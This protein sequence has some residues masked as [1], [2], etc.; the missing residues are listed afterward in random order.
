[1]LAT[2]GERLDVYVTMKRSFS[3]AP[4]DQILLMKTFTV[5]LLALSLPMHGLMAASVT[6]DKM[7]VYVSIIPQ[8][9]LV[10][11]IGGDRVATEVMVKPGYSPETYEPAPG[12]MRGIAR[13][14]IYFRVCMPFEEV[15]LPAV[16]TGNPIRIVDCNP[17]VH[18]RMP[19]GTLAH[20]KTRP[21]P[22]IWTDPVNARYLAR[23][24]HE[25]L[26]AE[27]PRHATYYMDNFK[28]LDEEL[29]DLHEY[30]TGQISLR[31]SP[32]LLV[33]HAAWGY[34]CDRYGLRQLA[35]EEDGKPRGPRALADLI[36]VVK[37]QN[38]TTLFTQ[39]EHRSPVDSAFAREINARV[40]EVDPLA[41][42]YIG[43]LKEVTR[44]FVEA[45]RQ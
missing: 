10:D 24:I 39:R 40:V 19:E 36:R 14:R 35:L 6:A 3:P 11:R 29:L 16:T 21:D 7:I 20:E 1:M 13:A 25:I 45:A 12:Q 18:Y 4:L 5:L 33:S 8:K 28:R 27:D 26:A 43:N 17:D 9:Y 15:F 37:A 2:R 22:H 31:N 38:I 23:Q 34:Y 30:I 41:E 32:Y 42:D 44:L